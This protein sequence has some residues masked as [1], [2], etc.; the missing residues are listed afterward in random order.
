[1]AFPPRVES[2][3][4][5]T[6]KK[7]MKKIYRFSLLLLLFAALAG[8]SNMSKTE[9]GVAT[10][11]AVGALGGAAVGAMAGHP[12]YGAAAGAATG[13]VI[14][15]VAGHSQENDDDG[16]Y[17]RRDRNDY[18]YDRNSR[19]SRDYDYDNDRS[20]RRSNY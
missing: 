8:C 4:V 6:P 18:N 9:K 19:R 16:Y 12:G 13:A 1:M 7:R 14:G 10:G 2:Y 3:R 5:S 11:A 20:Y 15:G 17:D